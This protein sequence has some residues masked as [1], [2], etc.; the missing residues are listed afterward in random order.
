MQFQ[1][2]QLHFAAPSL[3]IWLGLLLLAAIGWY[4]WT[5]FRRAA[6]PVR[7]GLLELLRFFI[8]ALIV[9]LL[10]QPEYHR[11]LNP[12][13]E[14]EIVILA[15]TTGSMTTVDATENPESA[16]PQICLLYTSPSPRD[17]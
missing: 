7:T 2:N 3:F 17:S 12:T 16:R 9:L 15:D 5:A 11:V 10:L 6:R 4:C 1:I 13:Q 14:P 8:A